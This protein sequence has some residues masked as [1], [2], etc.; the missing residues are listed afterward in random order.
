MSDW[1]VVA[2]LVKAKTREGGLVVRPAHSLPF[3]LQEGMSVVFVPPVL[4]TPKQAVITEIT[5]LKEDSRLV[6]FEGIDDIGEAE[7]LVGRFCLVRKS[8]LPLDY[9]LHPQEWWEGSRVYDATRGFLGVVS[10]VVENP[11]QHLLCVEGESGEIM[12]PFV[13]EFVKDVSEDDA[14]ID[15]AIPQSLLDL[16]KD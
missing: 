10:E 8:D 7:P 11:A 6:Y 4:K 1:A 12:I 13:S 15:V 5:S 2:K 16:S 9:P 3:L 14:R